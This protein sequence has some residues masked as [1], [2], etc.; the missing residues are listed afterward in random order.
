MSAANTD[1]KKQDIPYCLVTPTVPAGVFD[2]FADDPVAGMPALMR[3][4]AGSP[5]VGGFMNVCQVGE[6]LIKSYTAERLA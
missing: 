2:R 5:N 1:G 3:H 4:Q 6:T